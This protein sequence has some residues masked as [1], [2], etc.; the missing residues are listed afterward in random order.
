MKL[1]AGLACVFA[2]LVTTALA[3]TEKAIFIAPEAIAL[4]DAQPSLDTLQLHALTHRNSTLRTS[5]DV[6]FPNDLSPRGQDHW[7]L[8]R[9]LSQGQRYELR[10]CW[11]ATVCDLKDF[12]ERRFRHS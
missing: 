6:V 1:L 2:L 5:L 11:A 8:L 12:H 10:V 9:N 4:P 7:Y 3:N